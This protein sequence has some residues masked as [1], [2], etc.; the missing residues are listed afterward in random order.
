MTAP[1]TTIPPEAVRALRAAL[2]ACDC[3]KCLCDMI[4]A[5]LNAWPGMSQLAE[6]DSASIR[7][8]A[9]II[10]PLPQKETSE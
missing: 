1:D 2:T 9:A 3:D 6:N 4:R 7:E 5:A 10:L 8:M